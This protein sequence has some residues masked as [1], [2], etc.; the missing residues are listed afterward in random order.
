LIAY[1]KFDIQDRKT[2]VVI[3]PFDGGAPIQILDYT[4]DPMPWLRWA[5]DGH[6]LIYN[7]TNHGANNLWRLPLDGGPPQQITDFKSEQIWYF[8]FTRDGKQLAVARGGAT[9]DVVLISSEH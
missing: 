4:F 9:T 3:I 6:S 5:P 2:K 1:Y 7:D 8:D